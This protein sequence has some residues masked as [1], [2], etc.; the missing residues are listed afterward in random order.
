MKKLPVK[1]NGNTLAEYVAQEEKGKQELSIGQIKE[2]IKIIARVTFKR[3]VEMLNLLVR[4][5][6]K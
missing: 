1:L 3:P 4:L 2:V 6:K 5:G